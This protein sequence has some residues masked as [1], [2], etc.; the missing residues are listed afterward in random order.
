[1]IKMLFFDL[2][3]TQ[4]YSAA[5]TAKILAKL[6]ANNMLTNFDL[7]YTNQSWF[8]ILHQSALHISLDS[9]YLKSV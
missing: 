4:D 6:V 7:V 9:H 8:A 5:T 2:K 1:M 3:S